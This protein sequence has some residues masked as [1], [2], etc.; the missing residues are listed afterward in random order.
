MAVTKSVTGFSD[1]TAAD[2]LRRGLKKAR[3][4]AA[5]PL[6]LGPMSD[7]RA[8]NVLLPHV[9]ELHTS[10]PALISPAGSIS[11]DHFEELDWSLGVRGRILEY[12]HLW[13]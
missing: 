6:M 4:P 1:A 3:M 13:L 11:D 8:V 10:T 12:T 2:A 7:H 5:F 9:I